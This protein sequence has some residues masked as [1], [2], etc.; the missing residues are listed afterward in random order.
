MAT[1]QFTWWQKYGNLAQIASA[2]IALFGFVAVFLQINEIRTNGRS[3]N[4]RQTYLGYMDM[5]FKNPAY[6]VPDYQKIKS[7]GKDELVRYENFVTYF[8]YAC[9]EAMLSLDVRGEWRESCAYDLKYHLP[10]LCEKMKTEPAYLS[11]YNE[12]TQNL[13]QS[14]MRQFGVVSP[15]CKITRS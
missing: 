4:A 15:E 5:A 1:K 10:F 6:S 14:A 13:I 9:E 12:K 3:T 8:L 11:T 2:V 7:A